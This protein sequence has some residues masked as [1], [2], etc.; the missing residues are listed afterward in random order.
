MKCKMNKVNKFYSKEFIY[1]VKVLIFLGDAGQYVYFL[2]M[3]YILDNWVCWLKISSFW[4]IDLGN[5]LFDC[6][7]L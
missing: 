5:G 7:K 4:D 1:V 3:Q 6:N 2:C